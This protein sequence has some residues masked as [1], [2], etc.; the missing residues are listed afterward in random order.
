MSHPTP[1]ARSTLLVAAAISAALLL[2]A[3]HGDAG[4]SASSPAT[5]APTTPIP[6][7]TSPAASP[8]LTPVATPTQ[9]TNVKPPPAPAK[10]PPT[11]GKR[12]KTC[13][14]GW[15][16]PPKNGT[17]YAEPLKILAQQIGWKGTFVV[18][19]LRAFDGPESPPDPETGYLRLVRRWYVKGYV[20]QDPSLQGRFLIEKRVFGSGMSAVAPYDSKGWSSPDWVGFQYEGSAAAKAYPNLPGTWAGTPYDFVKGGQGLDIPGLPSQVVGC[21]SGT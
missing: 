1:S 6:T 3:C 13:I 12:N 4:T 16:T 20:K 11:K 18:T 5:A 21:L 7:V 8:F 10:P 2:G 15:S 19:D 14:D 9:A 17:D